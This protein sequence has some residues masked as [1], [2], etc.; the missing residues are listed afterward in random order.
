[1]DFHVAAESPTVKSVVSSVA[2]PEVFISY[3]WG[4]R[5]VALE[6]KKKLEENGIHC[7]MDISQMGG[8][9]AVFAQ[10]DAGIRAC[11]VQMS[12]SSCLLALNSDLKSIY[13][14]KKIGTDRQKFPSPR[15][16]FGE[17]VNLT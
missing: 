16:F 17:T 2:S 12:S 11:K 7:W 10:I 4:S 14:T 8:G 3:H 9:D 5:E 1:M 6:L 13:M 15:T